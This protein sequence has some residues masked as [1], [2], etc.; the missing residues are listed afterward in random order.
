M[1]S[2]NEVYPFVHTERIL[3]EKKQQMLD[4][5]S[6][7]MDYHNAFRERFQT[8]CKSWH[9]LLFP[10]QVHKITKVTN[11]AMGLGHTPQSDLCWTCTHYLKKGFS[12]TIVCIWKFSLCSSTTQ[13]ICFTQQS[14][15]TSAGH[16][17]NIY[18][19]SSTSWWSICAKRFGFKHRSEWI[20]VT[21]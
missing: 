9:R 13:W 20:T 4:P 19:W 2:D 10:N 5:N 17:K 7:C 14:W 1:I 8:Y 6:H 12:P 11:V 21:W 16:H 15:K 18:N 3:K